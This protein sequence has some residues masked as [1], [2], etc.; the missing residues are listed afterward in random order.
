MKTATCAACAEKFGYE[1]LLVNGNEVFTRRFCD[2]C[3]SVK[4]T[5]SEKCEKE[6]VIA[7]RR[8]AFYRECPAAFD[9]TDPRRLAVESAKAIRW[10]FGQ[11]GL[12][13]IGPTG[14]T[15]TR[16][17]WEILR[18][19]SIHEG[20]RFI[21]TTEIALSLGVTRF[22][23]LLESSYADR[24]SKFCETPILAIDDLGKAKYTDRVREALFHIVDVRT[25][26][27]RPILCTTQFNGKELVQKFATDGER[28]DE[29]AQQ[30]LRET[31][32]AW[33]RRLREFCE[34]ITLTMKES[35]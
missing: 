26:N 30:R 3:T 12:M 14:V 27:G 17:L 10:Q 9:H 8:S 34:P 24:L 23:L 5:E 1:E 25:T 33:V 7:Q 28:N 22:G 11:K 20:I 15:K 29:L 19:Q 4:R 2:S 31:G 16:T 6:E 35:K 13:L 32:E 21:C 18:W